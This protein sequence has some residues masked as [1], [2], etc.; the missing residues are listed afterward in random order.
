M[1]IIIALYFIL[2]ATSLFA[3]VNPNQCPEKFIITY[4]DINRGPLTKKIDADPILKAGWSVVKE[5]QKLELEFTLL[6]RTEVAQCIYLNKNNQAFL[7]TNNGI[8]E[9]VIP[10]VRDLYFR[11]KVL[12]FSND[13]IELAVD[14]ESKDIYAPV[15]Q[16]NSR[17]EVSVVDEVEVGEAEAVNIQVID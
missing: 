1:K 3:F 8:D 13:F 10:Y 5:T 15:L 2:Q 7:Q 16:T 17:G 6:K 11:T 4:Y 12:T 9:L 14:E